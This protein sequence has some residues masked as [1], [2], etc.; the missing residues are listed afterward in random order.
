MKRGALG[1][2]SA[3]LGST[4]C[5]QFGGSS[6]C[7]LPLM[8]LS[9]AS[10]LQA[11]ADLGPDLAHVFLEALALVSKGRDLPVYSGGPLSLCCVCA[12]HAWPPTLLLH[13]PLLRR[14]SCCRPASSP[15][16]ACSSPRGAARCCFK[17]E[18]HARS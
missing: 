9:A 12:P 5:A 14:A 2:M 13:R 4:R 11:S 17:L 16:P 10:A 8:A 1:C 15:S 3:V 7:C 18:G 6:V